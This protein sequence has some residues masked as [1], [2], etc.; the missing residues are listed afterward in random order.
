MPPQDRKSIKNFWLTLGGALLLN[1]IIGGASVYVT[2]Q[3]QE[4]FIQ[5]QSEVIREM[6]TDIRELRNDISDILKTRK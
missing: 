1:V 5:N 6:K 3:R 4:V 2:Q